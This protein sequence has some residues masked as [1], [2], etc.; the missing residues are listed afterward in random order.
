MLT[1]MR[2]GAGRVMES[3]GTGR[4]SQVNN[5]PVVEDSGRHLASDG[6]H[7]AYARRLT[8]SGPI[9]PA[10]LRP[11]DIDGSGTTDI[12]Y[13]GRDCITLHFNQSGNSWSAG[14]CDRTF[15]ETG[16]RAQAR[17]TIRWHITNPPPWDE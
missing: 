9:R 13:L 12:R 8:R 4:S 17:R 5:G 15:H 14:P 2:A 11:A 7:S 3:A 1:V 10:A 6:W 16:S